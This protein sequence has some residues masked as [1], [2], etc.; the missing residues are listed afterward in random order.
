MATFR[1][2][3]GG[4]KDNKEVAMENV[5]LILG[6]ETITFVRA[7]HDWDSYIVADVYGDDKVIESNLNKN[8]SIFKEE[9]WVNID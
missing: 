8:P 7:F 9:E 6:A 4:E 1:I 5:K 2:I 3:F